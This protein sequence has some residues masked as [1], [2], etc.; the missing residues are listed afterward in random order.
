MLINKLVELK[1]LN[2]VIYCIFMYVFSLNKNISF[3]IINK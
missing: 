1:T 3:I 2:G